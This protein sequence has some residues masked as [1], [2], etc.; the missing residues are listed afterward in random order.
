MPSHDA[1]VDNANTVRVFNGEDKQEDGESEEET[2]EQ[3]ETNE[4][5]EEGE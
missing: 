5:E 3:E 1:F 2:N 4:M